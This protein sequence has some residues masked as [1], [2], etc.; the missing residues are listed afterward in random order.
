M[1]L[2]KKKNNEEN[3]TD[4]ELKI[5]ADIPMDVGKGFRE[6]SDLD[7]DDEFEI[8]GD[9]KKTWKIFLKLF[10]WIFIVLF[11]ILLV[12]VVYF[13]LSYKIINKNVIGNEIN[14]GDY[15]IIS[16]YYQPSLEE[17]K[18]GDVIYVKND[19]FNDF[20]PLVLSYDEYEVTGREGYILFCKNDIKKNIAIE[21][22][23]VLY[24][25]ERK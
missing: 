1:G 19:S 2:F 16:R 18:V 25:K 22:P 5:L 10:K 14:I 6:I 9:Q 7:S 12:G 20:L 23:N 15:S 11:L 3:L 13:S 8:I 4:E 24:I 21:T 17:L